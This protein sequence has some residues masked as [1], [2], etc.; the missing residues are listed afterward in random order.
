M[1]GPSKSLLLTFGRGDK[2]RQ[3]DL[4]I[5]WWDPGR[6]PCSAECRL[7]REGGGV[8]GWDRDRDQEEGPSSL[9]AGISGAPAGCSPKLSWFQL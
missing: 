5:R 7:R 4:G 9:G 2:F 1:S 3:V 8:Q 6:S